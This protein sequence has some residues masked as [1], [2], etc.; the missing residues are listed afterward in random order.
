MSH[1]SGRYQRTPVGSSA[2]P[3]KSTATPVL[4]DVRVRSPEGT[5]RSGRAAQFFLKRPRLFLGTFYTVLA[6]AAM[7]LALR[8]PYVVRFIDI[9]Y[10][11]DISASVSQLGSAWSYTNLGT[12]SGINIYVLP[13]Y[14]PYVGL[15]AIGLPP[16]LI[17]ATT[18]TAAL[19]IAGLGAFWL[20]RELWHHDAR[21][22]TKFASLLT[23]IF[24][25][26]SMATVQIVFWDFIPTGVW[27]LALLPVELFLL[28]KLF[29]ILEE[30]ERLSLVTAAAFLVLTPFTLGANEP[31]ALNFVYLV[32]VVLIWKILT[33][34]KRVRLAA[35][36]SAALLILLTL[37]INAFW[38]VPESAAAQ[39]GLGG[40]P[41]YASNLSDF[42]S[43]TSQLNTVWALELR[44]MNQ[45]VLSWYGPLYDSSNPFSLVLLPLAVLAILPLLRL[46]ETGS[47]SAQQSVLILWVA[48]LGAVAIYTGVNSPI[49]ELGGKSL[50]LNPYVLQV[51][52][53]SANASGLALVLLLALLFGFGVHVLI[54]LGSPSQAGRPATAQREPIVDRTVSTGV[55]NRTWGGAGRSKILS[56]ASYVSVAAVLI[57]LPAILPAVSGSLIAPAPYQAQADV[58]SYIPALAEYVNAHAG[59]QYTMLVPGGFQEQNWTDY[60]GHGYDGYDIL[61]SEISTPIIDGTGGGLGGSTTAL[62][63]DAYSDLELPPED[64]SY[65]TLLSVLQVRYVVLEGD[66]GGS[67]PFGFPIYDNV[68]H[69]RDFLGAQPEISLVDAF[70][71]DY[72]FLNSNPTPAPVWSTSNASS[73]ASYAVNITSLWY[74]ATAARVEGDLAPPV[75]PV[76]ENSGALSLSANVTE[77]LRGLPFPGDAVSFNT[78]PLNISLAQFPTLTISFTTGNF[79]AVGF[80]F[81]PVANLSRDYSTFSSETYSLNNDEFPTGNAVPNSGWYYSPGSVTTVTIN[82]SLAYSE[83]PAALSPNGTLSHLFIT[84]APT[85]G[86]TTEQLRTNASNL[87]NLN[88]TI[89]SISL[90]IPFYS[91]ANRSVNPAL[92]SG[93]L[94]NLTSEFY[95]SALANSSEPSSPIK[96]TLLNSSISISVNRSALLHGLAFPYS[97]MVFNDLPL[98]LNVTT[99]PYLI[100]KFETDRFTALS[101]LV[102]NAS[103]LSTA[104]GG[105]EEDW[106]ATWQFSSSYPNAVPNVGWYYSP[107]YSV[108]M[109]ISLPQALA[110]NEEEGSPSELP[111]L[112]FIDIAL[113]P[114]LGNQTEQLNSNDST[115]HG[116]NATIQSIALTSIYQVVGGNVSVPTDIPSFLGVANITLPRFDPTAEILL[117]QSV[118]PTDLTSLENLS[119]SSRS[120]TEWQVAGESSDGGRTI[121]VLFQ[122]WD[123]LWQLLPEA[124]GLSVIAHFV[125]DGYANGWL[126][127]LPQNRAWVTFE[128]IYVGQKTLETGILISEVTLIAVS[129]L[130]AYAV[131]FRWLP[132]RAQ[133]GFLRPRAFNKGPYRSRDR[134]R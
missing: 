72:L 53:N 124:S 42:T 111:E 127:S 85:I 43:F 59:E 63:Q 13:S 29:R 134:S 125:V 87:H 47:K 3:T 77:Q 66:L 58:P 94:T 80:A 78:I 26:F 114:T 71:P 116:D 133:V 120:P 130:V 17:Q 96:P 52:R 32:G 15:A 30:E 14:L 90:N 41:G 49:F 10:P 33:S 113:S 54:S 122:R 112:N 118:L 27:A 48:L 100:V 45:G 101:I 76:R 123:P 69:M 57:L 91:W 88:S 102:S 83:S 106:S 73:A 39:A 131:L 46:R 107:D 110:N 23:G 65:G 16:W 109:A 4:T 79:T 95:R 61:A 92:S 132:T 108:T 82:V 37:L 62:L 20:S 93:K 81:S 105:F 38:I 119:I 70:G 51:V 40:A 104:L 86:D 89:D 74:N 11:Y 5:L 25:M 7:A 97:P 6:A 129:G 126:I 24:Y 75:A 36:L 12:Y 21:T 64:V 31:I 98:H 60:G 84:M 18:D 28:L 117:Q 34:P 103:N 22:S 55:R 128:I 121:V 115:I 35:G 2:E 50:F 8:G 99:T 1:I 68:T 9:Q 56:D 44:G 19:A 67:F